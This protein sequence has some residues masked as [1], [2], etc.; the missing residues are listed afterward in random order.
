MFAKGG[1][2]MA[3]PQSDIAPGIDR[4]PGICGGEPCIQGTRIPVWVLV[5]SR[6]LG[7]SEAEILKSY[8]MLRTEN[9]ANAWAYEESH[10][11]DIARQIA[12]NEEPNVLSQLAYQGVRH[13]AGLATSCE[14][15][16]A[17]NAALN[18]GLYSPSLADVAVFLDKRLSDIGPVFQEALRELHIAVPESCD[19]CCWTLL[20]HYIG[21]IA[22]RY[23]LP[24]EGL[25][26][27]MHEVFFGFNLHEKS[28]RYVGDSHDI[29]Q[30]ISAYY[31]Y[32]DLLERPHEV[33]FNGLYGR[34]AVDALDADVVAKCASWLERHPVP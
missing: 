19:D 31:G 32:D 11:D 26:G 9:L 13:L 20:R 28:T 2:S 15:R 34:A 6:R 8:P 33:S 30:L 4:N 5:Q 17:A 3:N 27:L 22:N 16:Q 12:E 10:R 24:R 23:V 21:Q 18:A 7:M 25:G 29:E 1:I 14:L